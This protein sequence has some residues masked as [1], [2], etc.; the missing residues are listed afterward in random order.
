MPADLLTRDLSGALAGMPVERA[1]DVEEAHRAAM[2]P[3]AP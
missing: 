3:L 1:A 2:Q